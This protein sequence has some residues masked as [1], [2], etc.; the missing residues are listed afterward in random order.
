MSTFDSKALS[1]N[2][3]IAFVSIQSSLSTKRTYSPVAFSRSMF[4]TIAIPRFF[5]FS[6]IFT[7]FVR[8][9]YFHNTSCSTCML[10]SGVQSFTNTYSISEY[11]CE[12][13]VSRHLAKYFSTLYTG[14]N[15][16]TFINLSLKSICKDSVSFR[17]YKIKSTNFYF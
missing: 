12:N 16:D 9:G 15:I 7:E 1:T 14:T 4:L 5:L 6:I 17:Q 11:V 10:L 2:F 3:S 13:K 8:E